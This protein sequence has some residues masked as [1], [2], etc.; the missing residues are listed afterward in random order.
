MKKRGWLVYEEEH[1]SKNAAFIDWF[2]QEAE[3]LNIT[4]DFILQSNISFGAGPKGLF[5][6]VNG[7]KSN[8][9]DF[10]IMRNIY[11]LFNMQL[12]KMNIACFNP[13]HVSSI[14]NDKAATHQYLAPHGIPMLETHFVHS[15]DL[16]TNTLPIPF[17]FI[18][19]SRTGRGGEQVFMV[20]EQEELVEVL[21]ALNEHE[22]ILQ[23]LA[24]TPGKD[25]RVYVLGDKI[26][27]AVLRKNDKSFKANYSLGGSADAYFLNEREKALVSQITKLFDFGLAGIDFLFDKEN[28][29]LFNEIE[30]VVGCRTLCQTSEVNIVQL[31]L[32]F[33]LDKL[34]RER[35]R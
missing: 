24:G 28:N 3:N 31:Y 10:V 12:E 33:I 34:E 18:L 8:T 27:G 17:P 20:N 32:S 25:L 30:D 19:K 14:C 7:I 22:L 2:L 13:F 23:P 16:Q 1:A 11:P 9:P 29:L 35:I 4:L 5:L 26:V 21:D 15:K 6:S